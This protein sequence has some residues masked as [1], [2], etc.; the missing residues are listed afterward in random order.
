MKT[1]FVLL[2]ALQVTP[3]FAANVYAGSDDM[4]AK[5]GCTFPPIDALFDP[6]HRGEQRGGLLH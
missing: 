4:C 6:F 3:S 1:I 5:F 2:L